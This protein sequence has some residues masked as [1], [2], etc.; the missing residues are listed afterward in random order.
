MYLL[1]II[2]FDSIITK[3]LGVISYCCRYVK[4][5]GWKKKQNKL[6]FAS[7]RN[8]NLWYCYYFWMSFVFPIC[9]WYKDKKNI[10]QDEAFIPSIKKKI[11]NFLQ[12]INKYDVSM[13][14]TWILFTFTFQHLRKNKNS[15]WNSKACNKAD[16]FFFFVVAKSL[17]K[18]RF[19][20]SWYLTTIFL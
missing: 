10:L 7:L 9:T 1:F 18:I 11:K 5:L 3:W 15:K 17:S 13:R 19:R 16:V 14:L 4:L 12:K 20:L 8:F 2:M 6:L